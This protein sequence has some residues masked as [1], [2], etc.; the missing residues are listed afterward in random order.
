MT[1]FSN[2]LINASQ[3]SLRIKRKKSRKKITNVQN[4][5]WFD[6]ECKFKRHAVRKLAN[7]KH[8]DPTNINIRNEYHTALTIYKE[9]LEIKKNQFQ[10]D[11]L[12][13]L[14]RTAENNPN[15]FW[16]TLQN[17]SD[18]IESTD[19]N[20]NSP[21]GDEWYNHFSKLH[22]KHQ[23]NQD[24]EEIIKNLKDKEKSKDEYNTLDT[25]ITEYEIRNTA[26]KLK[27]RKAV[28]IFRQ[29]K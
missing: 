6:K 17:I 29:N 27:L 18:E 5:K 8:R 25:D 12:I 28:A 1:E 2:N 24:H 7:K 19:S 9:T 4:K 21:T 16:K 22:S 15:S 20:H 10:N 26:L 11:E 23:M 13:E 3:K 14:E